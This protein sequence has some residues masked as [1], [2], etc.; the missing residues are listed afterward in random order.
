MRLAIAGLSLAI[1]LLVGWMLFALH[2]SAPP[3]LNRGSRTPLATETATAEPTPPR[4]AA[5]A[6]ALPLPVR[7]LP[8]T[9][10]APNAE[11]PP[12]PAPEGDE[13]AATANPMDV[14]KMGKTV[15]EWRH[16]YGV[17]QRAIQE[18]LF[19]YQEIIDRDGSDDQPSAAQLSDA[20]ARVDE[21]RQRMREDLIELRKIEASP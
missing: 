21:L 7:P 14:V 8:T 16:Y 18:D 6:P 1:V 5:P 9:P 19:K 15:R 17:R 13:A 20:R 4:P 3:D 2:P 11:A 10:P 12:S